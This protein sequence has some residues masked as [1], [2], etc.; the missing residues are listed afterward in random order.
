MITICFNCKHC[1]GHPDRTIEN[2]VDHWCH[3]PDQILTCFVTGKKYWPYCVEVNTKGACESFSPRMVTGQLKT[4]E[5]IICDFRYA[6]IGNEKA[7]R[8]AIE[9]QYMP[10]SRVLHIN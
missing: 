10:G 5:G 4:R 9:T 1:Q 2:S 8:H 3:C 7:N 6:S